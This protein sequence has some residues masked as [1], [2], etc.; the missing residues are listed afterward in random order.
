MLRSFIV[1]I[2]VY[3]TCQV[4]VL[5]NEENQ[6]FTDNYCSI[7]C[8]YLSIHNSFAIS[9]Q[10]PKWRTRSTLAYFFANQ[11]G[12]RSTLR[13]LM[14]QSEKNVGLQWVA[15]N[16]LFYFL[17]FYLADRTCVFFSFFF[18]RAYPPPLPTPYLAVSPLSSCLLSPQSSCLP[19]PLS[20]RLSS[21]LS[22]CLPSPLS[23]YLPS[24]LSS[25]LPSPLSSCL[26]SPL[27]VSPPLC[28]A[29]SPLHS[30]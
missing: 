4:T 18:P 21:T 11:K 25:C 7:M 28:L 12:C 10:A 17:F 5:L 1:I 13:C 16:A 27:S 3:L 30:V 22:S 26:P 14:G 2:H 23:S 20:S 9:T 24:P 6:Q 8:L 15:L 29:V 19:S